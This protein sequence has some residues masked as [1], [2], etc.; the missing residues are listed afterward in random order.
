MTTF[1]AVV[2][3][4]GLS[5]AARHLGIA[6]PTVTRQIQTLEERIGVRLLQRTTR[7]FILTEAG[8]A[9]YERGV[10]ILDDV[11]EADAVAHA[12]QTTAKG[13]VRL[14][15]SPTI[16][17]E[18][19]TL[20]ARY[21]ALNPGTSFDL[22]TSSELIDLFDNRTDVAIRDDP[23]PESSLVVRR[24]AS[25]EWT[26]CASPG[27]VG[28]HGM[29][30]LLEELAEHNCLVYVSGQRSGEWQF[31]DVNGVRSVRVSGSLRSGDPH[32]LRT[33]ALSD[34]GIVFLPE[35]MVAED[36]DAGQL[37]RV[38]NGHSASERVVKAVFP[39]RRQLP[40][41]VRA[42]LDFAAIDFGT[43][44]HT[45]LNGSRSNILPYADVECNQLRNLTHLIPNS[46]STPY[47]HR[48]PSQL[49]VRATAHPTR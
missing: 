11:K 27:Y 10:K 47:Q 8:Q 40:I 33:A 18:V 12:Y 2:E 19:S 38:L 42:F 22:T 28:S 3:K 20:V 32:V 29:P 30:I 5:A 31:S 36:L 49:A 7:K 6:P 21:V 48:A 45:E 9:F 46:V 34:Q 17:K 1:V 13:I 14:N 16:S 15:S 43:P 41:K 35:T 39:S 23:I 26:P 44:S 25:S 24:L 37:I 4:G